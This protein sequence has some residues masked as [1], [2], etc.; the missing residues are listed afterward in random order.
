[1]RSTARNHWASFSASVVG[2]AHLLYGT[3]NQDSVLI[4]WL[5]NAV[6]AV[7]SD[8][9]G[10][11]EYADVGSRTACLAVVAAAKQW[12]SN[13][14]REPF[15]LLRLIQTLW[16][17][18]LR[19]VA[20]EKAGAT[21]LFVIAESSGLVTTGRLG[22]GLILVDAAIG[23]L[24]ALEETKHGFANQTSVLSDGGILK[25]WEWQTLHIEKSGGCICLMTDGISEDLDRKKLEMVPNIF[26]QLSEKSP[27]YSQRYLKRELTTWTTP[28]HTDD[29][30]IAAL[31]RL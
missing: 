11:H 5:K 19:P 30:T 24:S 4:R 13:S 18:K 3:P 26:R 27:S 15:D 20:P 17:M 2:P 14:K 25:Q 16:L 1:M 12:L 31:L 10:S 9:L 21:C 8:G 22:D 23:E 6:V 28:H 7:V 29:K